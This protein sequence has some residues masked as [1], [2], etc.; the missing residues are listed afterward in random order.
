MRRSTWFAVAG[1]CASMLAWGIQPAQAATLTVVVPAAAETGVTS[2]V[3]L[4]AGDTV[5][6]TATGTA[7]TVWW[8]P[9]TNPDGVWPDG[10]SA[11]C[12]GIAETC[13]AQTTASAL[14][15]KV[16]AGPWTLV[17]S[18]PVTLSGVG[19]VRLAYNDAIGFFGDNLDGY[20]AR[21]DV[22]RSAPPC[23]SITV[24]QPINPNGS[25]VFK[26]GSTVPVKFGCDVG[27]LTPTLG[28]TRL[29]STTLGTTLESEV[30]ATATNGS[31]FRYDASA[32]QYIY[33][34][35]TKGM[36][37]G[38]YRLNVLSGGE[39]IGAVQFSLR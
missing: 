18:G 9:P 6:I 15:A 12:I 17:G 33:N 20:T 22:T 1:V 26:G 23:A 36:A 32:A 24:R 39:T 5:T 31:A 19:A 14:I 25:S 38:T 29:T 27:T 4:N 30:T 28:L 13:L 2:G 10:G 7:H 11:S 16:G 8:Q 3:D 21:L 37:T 35:S 34:L